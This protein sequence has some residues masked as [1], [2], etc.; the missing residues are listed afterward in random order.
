MY[1]KQWATDGEVST[2]SLLVPH[3]RVPL[4]KRHSLKGMAYRQHL[5][6]Q[7]VGGTET[8]DIER[9]LDREFEA[10][11]ERAI[12]LAVTDQRLSS[13]DWERLVRFA[14]SQDVRTPAR[15]REF[16]SRQTQSM[17]SML[18]KAL[19]NAAAKL[20]TENLSVKPGKTAS[21][22]GFP[23]TLHVDDAR[24]GAATLRAETIIGRK[25]WLWSLR[26]IL[27]TTIARIS[28]K[29]WSIRKAALG[30]S[31]PT[32]DNPLIRLNYTNRQQYDFDGG[33]SVPNGD[34]L[35]PLS[36]THVLHR[37]AGSRPPL[38]RQRLGRTES[39]EIERMIIEHA[40]RYV[41][42]KEQFEIHKIR[43]RVV[44]LELHKAEQDAWEKWK[45]EQAKAESD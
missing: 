14:V 45:T 35:L 5:Y 16:M 43:E 36:P 9:W 2:Y 22:N 44:S 40:D 7:I 29:G 28:C 38:C 27:T 42:A 19:Q 26:Y 23:L 11:A 1:L 15:M 6:T 41:F 20:A 12:R 32:S 13:D 18:E 21:K 39:E 30:C 37:C 4:W 10:P 8:D 33:W 3:Q 25:L 34:V 24:D 17:P 31:W